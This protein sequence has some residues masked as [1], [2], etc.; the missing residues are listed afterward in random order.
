MPMLSNR[1]VHSSND[2]DVFKLFDCS[3]L[4]RPALDISNIAKKCVTTL[5]TD[6]LKLN[7]LKEVK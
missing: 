4:I 1:I 3:I 5:L 7:K 6:S 2:I